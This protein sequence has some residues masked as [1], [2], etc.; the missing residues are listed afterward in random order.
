[1]PLW[2]FGLLSA[3]HL[4]SAGWLKRRLRKLAA[5]GKAPIIVLTLHRVADDGATPQTTPVGQFIQTIE[6]LH[7]HFDVVSLGEAQRRVRLSVNYRPCV[8]LTFDDGWAEN[9]RL[10]LP[11][12]VSRRM[13]CT[14]F[15]SSRLLLDASA[16]DAGAGVEQLCRLTQQGVEIGAQTHPLDET[17]R[18]GRVQ[19]L[20]NQIVGCRNELESALHCAVRWFAFP[21]ADREQL[22]PQAFQAAY[23]AGY[24]GVVTA[25]G[26][27]NWPGDDPF[28]LQRIAVDGPTRCAQ[29]A[30]LLDPF[31]GRVRRFDYRG[32]RP[33][34]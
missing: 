31:W 29:H 19:E 13:P 12:L 22:H 27:Y 5:D 6:W 11:L 10:A 9:C 8:S 33:D 2:R 21:T 1:M 14:Y 3:W 28:H 23:D 17:A 30:A 16:D 24:D 32:P 26:G 34:R 15:I 4:V 7:E 20:Y 25:Y 18:P